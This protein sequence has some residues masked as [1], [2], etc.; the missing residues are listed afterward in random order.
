[1]VP[2]K[3]PGFIFINIEKNLIKI[4][5]FGNNRSRHDFGAVIFMR[6]T[7][8]KKCMAAL[9]TFLMCMALLIL[10]QILDK[11]LLFDAG[12]VYIFYTQSAS[13]NAQIVLVNGKNAAAAKYSVRSLAGESTSY[14]DS[15]AAFAQAEKYGAKLVF[16]E[17]AGGVDNYYY[18]SARLGGTVLI[19]GAAVNLH[20]AVRADSAA[21]GS[22]LIF[23]GY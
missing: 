1:M 23:G 17:R 6:F 12:E 9:F 21:V 15:A 7:L 3:R 2:E 22:P 8:L 16:T 10:P 13:S 20:I 19:G 4:E 5:K 11:G 18:Y 14:R